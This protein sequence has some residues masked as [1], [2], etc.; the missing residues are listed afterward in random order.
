[1]SENQCSICL[2]D[3]NPVIIQLCENCK[4]SLTCLEDL[5]KYIYGYYGGGRRVGGY[6]FT[7]MICK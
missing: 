2:S 4:P 3:N 6:G 5:N 1:M 7:C